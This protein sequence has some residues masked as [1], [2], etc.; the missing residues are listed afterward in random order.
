MSLLRC[1][2]RLAGLHVRTTGSVCG[3]DV[4]PRLYRGE[5]SPAHPRTGARTL[6]DACALL[7]DVGMA[8]RPF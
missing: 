7:S 2:V 4:H 6:S 3:G 5:C 8:F 1:E